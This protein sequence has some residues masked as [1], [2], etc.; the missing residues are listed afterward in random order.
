M[1]ISSHFP[2]FLWLTLVA[3]PPTTSTLVEARPA[4]A[5]IDSLPI[6]P[7]ALAPMRDSFV[8]RL[9][10]KEIGWTA[11]KLEKIPKGKRYVEHTMIVGLV[12]QTTTVEF[13]D[14]GVVKRVVQMGEAQGQP[15]SIE[16]EYRDGRAKGTAKTVSPE[17]EKTVPI[18]T[19]VAAGTVDDNSLTAILPTLP[20]KGSSSWSFAVFSAGQNETLIT[21]LA[22]V[23]TD[24]LT[25]SD[26]KVEAYRVEWTGAWQPATFWIATAKSHRVVKIGIANMPLEIVVAR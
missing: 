2:G 26:K 3:A 7:K 24:T 17:G 23:A 22:V 15:T 6:N 8:I 14:A 18:D 11:T 5:P 20:W 4:A 12:N 25:I 9:Q 16:V 21:K 1:A 19:S 13:T 10:G